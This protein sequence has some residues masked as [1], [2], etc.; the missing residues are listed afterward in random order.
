MTALNKAF[1]PFRVLALVALL[2]WAAVFHLF[3]LLMKATP[4]GFDA[5][6]TVVGYASGAYLVGAAPVPGLAGLV[7]S[8]VSPRVC[9]RG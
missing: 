9:Q 2:L 4:R 5:T 3:L 6:L 8:G 7:A 1:P